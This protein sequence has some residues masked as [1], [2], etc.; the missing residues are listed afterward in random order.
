MLLG[1]KTQLG[2]CIPGLTG[3]KN[4]DKNSFISVMLATYF[5]SFCRRKTKLGIASRAAATSLPKT[6]GYA[7]W[8]S[9]DKGK[10]L[11]FPSLTW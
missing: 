10:K 7:Q 5:F 11:F 1:R 3:K 2:V 4:K 9:G 6:L 8:E